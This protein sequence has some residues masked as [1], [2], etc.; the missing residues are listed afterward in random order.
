MQTE[1]VNRFYK[2]EEPV[3]VIDAA[4]KVGDILASS[5]LKE[6]LTGSAITFIL[7]I[8]GMLLGY[9]VV[10]QVFRR[11]GAEGIGVYNLLLGP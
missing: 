10:I 1:A 11:Y 5:H 2:F 7:K 6:M 3:V 9:L 8:S 4:A